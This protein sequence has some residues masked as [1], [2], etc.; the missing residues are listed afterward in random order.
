MMRSFIDEWGESAERIAQLAKL[1]DE[2]QP[3]HI[4]CGTAFARVLQGLIDASP[5]PASSRYC[6]SKTSSSAETSM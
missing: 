1:L 4:V 3:A 5:L 2:T 6:L